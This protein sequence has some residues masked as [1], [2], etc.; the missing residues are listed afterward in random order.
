MEQNFSNPVLVPVP[1]HF[2]RKISRGYD[3][4][5]VI[6][7][8]FKKLGGEN[9]IKIEKNILK[10]TKNTS[11]QY[12]KKN[13]NKRIE[14]VKSSIKVLNSEKIKGKNILLFDDVFTTGA[15]LKETKKILKKAGAKK[16]FFITICH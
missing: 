11:P 5:K 6:L 2:F 12:T 1:S 10:K 8:N 3:Q 15:T 9:F 13:K 4:N 7:K 14:N 16:V